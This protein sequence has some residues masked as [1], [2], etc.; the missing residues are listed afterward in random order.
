MLNQKRILI[1][2]GLL[3]GLAVGL[4][5]FGAHALKA[6]LLQNGR[7]D[8]YELATRYH[9]Y[10]ALALVILGILYAKINSRT[11]RLSAWMF[12]AGILMFSGSLY[13]MAIFNTTQVALIT[14]LGGVCF[15]A[16]WI[17]FAVAVAKAELKD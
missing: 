1:I 3:A 5:A 15:L 9:I 10:H 13:V 4:G 8:T 16:G 12:V 14:P 2:G 6:L 11:F 17:L 7:V